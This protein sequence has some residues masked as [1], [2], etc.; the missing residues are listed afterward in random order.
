MAFAFP[1]QSTAQEWTLSRCI[2]YAL[3]NNIQIRQQ[4]INV[5]QQEIS[6]NSSKNNRLPGVSASASES[7]SFGRGLT[8]DNTY[9]NTNTSSTG[10][11]IGAD[12]PV[13]QG[14]RIVRDIAMKELNLAASTADLAKAKDDIRVAVA[15]SY[16]QILYNNEIKSV[17]ESQVELDSLQLVRLAE[18]HKN[19]KTSAAEVARQRATLE[20]SRLSLTQARNNLSISLL[21]LS[22]LLELPSPEGFMVYCPDLSDSM[23]LLEDPEFI[24]AQALDVKP[25]VKA[26]EIRLDYAKASVN[27]AKSSYLPTISLSGGLGSNFYTANGYQSLSFASQM[28][29]NFSQYLGLSLSVPIFDRFSTRNNV[30]SAKLNVKS[31][32]LALENV[33]KSLYKEIQ[34]AYYNAVASQS[35]LQSSRLAADA[36]Q[37][38]FELVKGRYENG[39]AA[40]TEYNEAKVSMFSALSNLA[41]ARYECQFQCKLLDFYKG[42]GMDF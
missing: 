25:S 18:M 32:E 24:Y 14:F 34:Q 36:A 35:K 8:A 40:I 5:S 20:Q 12:V 33:R 27:L 10:F 6:L 9:A 22:Q 7:M 19:G 39:K 31:Q 13:F 28:K 30:K 1:L 41:Q 2:E 16:V 17:A 11:S 38:A 42:E 29:N 26:E 3:E 15:Q 4:E 23:P 37:E 21:D